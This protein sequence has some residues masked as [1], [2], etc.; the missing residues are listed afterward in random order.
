MRREN[1]SVLIYRSFNIVRMEWL[2]PT[3]L[4][5]RTEESGVSA[6]ISNGNC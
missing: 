5:T 3:R 1:D 4:V 6:K 2:A